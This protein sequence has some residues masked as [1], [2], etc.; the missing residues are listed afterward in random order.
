LRSVGKEVGR[1]LKD[2]TDPARAAEQL[3]RYAEKLDPW[4]EQAAANMVQRCAR[5]NEQS[6]RAAA[7]RWGISVKGMLSTDITAA[8]EGKVRENIRLIKSIPTQAAEKVGMLAQTAIEQS[9]R[10]ETLAKK[11]AAQGDVAMSRARTIAR[12]EISKTGA[13]LTQ[14]RAESVGSEGYIWR[15]ARDGGTRP[16]HAA[17]E[18]RFVKWSQPPTLDGMTGHAGEFPN[19]R[20][21]AEPVVHDSAGKEVGS[22]IPTMAEE[23][24]SG[25]HKLRSLW[26]RSGLN[27]VM[28]HIEGTPLHNVERANFLIEKLTTYSM[29]PEH[30]DGKD[31]ARV[32]KRV[33][34]MDKSHAGEVMEQVMSQLR[35]FPAKRGRI[36]HHGER[37]ETHIPV[38]GPNG[39]TV[40]VLAA[41]IYKKEEKEGIVRTVP[42][43]TTCYIPKNA[44]AR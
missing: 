24:Q 34:N 27:P 4:A 25:E 18:G 32:W 13:A 40:D 29:D 1:I 14:A 39:A 15:T 12:T 41:W 21:Y 3:E 20:C 26:E 35:K 36:D 28:P 11:I 30:P 9:T 33:L 17:M 38:T 31:K 16:S 7:N 42:R 22:P 5:K 37:F 6:W 8:I 43:L 10:A 2:E 19:D 44:K 23:K